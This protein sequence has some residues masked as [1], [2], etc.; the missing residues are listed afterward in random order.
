MTP[1][2]RAATAIEAMLCVCVCARCDKEHLVCAKESVFATVKEEYE[3]ETETQ[4]GEELKKMVNFAGKPKRGE[5]IRGA[6]GAQ[7]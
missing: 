2:A 3:K 6:H 4:S 7:Q 5:L 1:D